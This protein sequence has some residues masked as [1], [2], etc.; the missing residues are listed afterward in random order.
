MLLNGLE[1][2]IFTH[3]KHV[4]KRFLSNA[5]LRIQIFVFKDIL[6]SFKTHY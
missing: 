1:Q 5:L 4:S 6:K 2:T 3:R